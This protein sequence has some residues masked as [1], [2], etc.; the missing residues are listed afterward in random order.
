MWIAA[1]TDEDCMYGPQ[2]GN[3]MV[4]HSHDA[5]QL[6][7]E[8]TLPHT[9]AG[10]PAPRGWLEDTLRGCTR[11][12]VME[13]K[14]VLRELVTNA[15][16]HAEPPIQVRLSMPR[17]GRVVRIEVQDAAL[18]SAS[19]WPMGKGLRLVRGL[20]P[21]WGI[22]HLADG[23]IVWAELPVLVPPTGG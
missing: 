23:K 20:C 11:G 4:T 2:I 3:D 14:V 5:G 6:L 15:C 22:E 21:D 16:S 9:A 10:F 19:G 1:A 18:S 7:G 17:T 8:M 13:V 12:F